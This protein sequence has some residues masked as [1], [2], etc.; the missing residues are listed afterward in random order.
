MVPQIDPEDPYA[1]AP[2]YPDDAEWFVFDGSTPSVPIDQIA[3]RLGDDADVEDV[4]DA[5][6]PWAVFD[7][8]GISRD[9]VTFPRESP[10]PPIAVDENTWRIRASQDQVTP[11][12]ENGHRLP[13]FPDPV[14]EAAKGWLDGLDAHA[15][16]NSA[17]ASADADG[18]L[19]DVT[20]DDLADMDYSDLRALAS[21]TE[22]VNG[23]AGRDEIEDA[24]TD[25]LRE[26]D[27]DGGRA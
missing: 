21:A 15:N 19:A 4:R 18:P 9:S 3:D 16:A 13:S 20:V 25:A 12:D 24:L 22:G 1:D 2:E 10:V 8:G 27:A 6:P 14:V 23:N 7:I 5:L 17:G 11:L 26:R